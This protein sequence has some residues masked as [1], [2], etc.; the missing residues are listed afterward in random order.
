MTDAVKELSG[1]RITVGIA[2]CGISAGALPV[3]DFLKKADT[4]M[5]VEGVG[6]AGMCYAEPIVTVKQKDTF[7]IYGYVTKENVPFLLSKAHSE[8]ISLAETANI[9][10]NTFEPAGPKA[11][12]SMTSKR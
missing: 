1:E 11:L 3:L 5:L 4:G 12:A 7:S 6:C 8:A 10:T 2:T 9:P